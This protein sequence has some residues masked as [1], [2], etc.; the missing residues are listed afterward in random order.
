MRHSSDIIT[1]GVDFER[2]VGHRWIQPYTAD[3]ALLHLQGGFTDAHLILHDDMSNLKSNVWIHVGQ[4]DYAIGVVTCT[5]AVGVTHAGV[6]RE[7]DEKES[8]SPT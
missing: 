2:R 6:Q 7:A 5:T 4:G 3:N 8:L 1:T